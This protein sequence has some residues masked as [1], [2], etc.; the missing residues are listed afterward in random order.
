[1]D[2]NKQYYKEDI[3]VLKDN[4]CIDHTINNTFFVLKKGKVKF[5]LASLNFDFY[6]LSST[7]YFGYETFLK[8]SIRPKIMTDKDSIISIYQINS[9]LKDLFKNNSKAA[10]SIF[11]FLIYQVKELSTILNK[12]I[13]IKFK[14]L[15]ILEKC[16]LISSRYLEGES[17]LNF[18]LSQNLLKHL[19]DDDMDV[20]FFKVNHL[21]WKDYSYHLPEKIETILNLKDNDLINLSTKEY[22]LSFNLFQVLINELGNLYAQ[23]NNE[24]TQIA[25]NI[26]ILMGKKIGIFAEINDKLAIISRKKI[27][28]N[29][30]KNYINFIVNS[31]PLLKEIKI[32]LEDAKKSLTLTKNFSKIDVFFKKEEKIDWEDFISIDKIQLMYNKINAISYIVDEPGNESKGRQEKDLK[33]NNEINNI[34]QELCVGVI[35]NIYITKIKEDIKN[36]SKVLFLFN[37]FIL[38]EAKFNLKEM[39]I[40]ETYLFAFVKKTDIHI[41]S[42]KG[43][44]EY[45]IYLLSQW[46]ELISLDKKELSISEYNETFSDFL[47]H[48]KK[49]SD[50]QASKTEILIDSKN[51]NQEDDFLHFLRMDFEIKNIF[52]MI[53]ALEMEKNSILPLYNI[54]KLPE[55]LDHGFLTREKVIQE[56][57]E[58]RKIDY[59]I[60]YREINYIYEDDV[61]AIIFVEILPDIIILPVISDKIMFWQVN[62]EKDRKMRSRLI[63]PFVFLGN[64]Q[65]SLL[66]ALGGYRWEMCKV[67][68][69]NDWMDSSNGGLTGK[70]YNFIFF[71]KKNSKLSL[72]QK[73]KIESSLKTNRSNIKNI[74]I[75][76]Y[77]E[78]IYYES[79]ATNRFNKTLRSIMFQ[80]IPFPKEYQKR[81]FREQYFRS[82]LNQHLNMTQKKLNILNNRLKKLKLDT[83]ENPLPYELESYK[84]LLLEN[85]FTEEKI[86]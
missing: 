10:V 60:F 32:S 39:N 41:E 18:N 45:Q 22:Y 35:K 81:L 9:D 58:I 19:I 36:S 12:F 69:D 28:W 44:E 49:D 74:F 25:E 86:N 73:K 1:M 8:E 70:F 3:S 54:N 20:H 7:C 62:S 14:S 43:F 33:S 37:F 55:S 46:I 4:I 16:K 66:K 15:E 27:D 40:L 26:E 31:T 29:E 78:W 53:R 68:K 34:F 83:P 30:I 67:T 71:Y 80:Y 84:K 59:S 50:Y 77:V 64:F 85:Y 51:S 61:N 38:D 75:N 42:E 76:H 72:I 17:D 47:N 2:T 79:K 24:V 21:S 56:L 5:Q 57:E 23:L 48:K 52:T 82:T 65:L 11:S 13:Q 6:H 63:V